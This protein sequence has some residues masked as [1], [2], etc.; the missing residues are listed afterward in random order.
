VYLGGDFE[1]VS[2]KTRFRSVAVDTSGNVLP[3]NPNVGSAPSVFLP[4]ATKV[5]VGGGFSDAG[6]IPR[7]RL[8]A[9]DASGHLTGFNVP[10]YGF[11]VKKVAVN[12]DKIY[13][14]GEISTVGG[15]PRNGLAAISLDGVV[16]S[17][18]PDPGIIDDFAILGD[19]VYTHAYITGMAR[20][21]LTTGALDTSWHPSVPNGGVKKIAVSGSTIYVA[22]GLTQA[23][24]ND[25]V[26]ATRAY[27]A[28]FD[29]SGNLLPWNPGIGTGVWWEGVT[30]LLATPTTVYLGGGFV[31]VGCASPG[32]SN[33]VNA[34]TTRNRAAAVDATTGVLD[35]N[36]NPNLGPTGPMTQ[37]PRS[38]AISGSTVY[39][40]GMFTSS[41]GTT[42]NRLL[43]IGTDGTLVSAWDANANN[44]VWAVRP[45]GSSVLVAGQFTTIGGQ[46]SSY[47]G[48]VTQGTGA[49][50]SWYS[51]SYALEVLVGGT[52]T[53]VVGSSTS[54]AYVNCLV[55]CASALPAAQT[56]TLTATP[57]AGSSF[58]GWNGACSGTS[59]SCTV[60]TTSTTSV[61]ANFT[62]CANVADCPG[63]GGG[64]GGGGTGGGGTNGGGGTT[65]RDTP[66]VPT[67][68]ATPPTVF[69][70]APGIVV[71]ETRGEVGL[72][73]TVPAASADLLRGANIWVAPT[74]KVTFVQNSLPAGLK[75]VNGKLVA[76][77]PGTYKIKVKIKRKNGDTVIRKI[78]VTVG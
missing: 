30:A 50:E 56:V 46:A 49:R 38:I 28:A 64:T 25:G 77:Q 12:A 51:S 78:K 13:V 10:V 68:P 58:G 66:A 1:T 11:D 9:I 42:R 17:W 59:T 15:L 57:D 29:T 63:G 39:M 16:S 21:D 6:G 36:W 4:T 61:E 27:A 18:A 37:L 52:G 43:A 71:G 65:N 22:G 41:N 55:S 32:G 26:V 34:T 8:A 31:S 3:W 2:G 45:V 35:A 60:S 67:T 73:P 20:H 33:C 47:I 40:A 7:S 54:G 72:T 53:G 23:A 5:F 48:K 70:P 44:Q 24:G 14:G 74:S 62:A 76:S 19:K 75:V 69:T